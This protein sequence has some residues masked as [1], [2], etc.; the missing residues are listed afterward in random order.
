MLVHFPPAVNVRFIY[1]E[2]VI[3]KRVSG[4]DRW[5]VS[6]PVTR[7]KRGGGEDTPRRRKNAMMKIWRLERRTTL[8]A[9]LLGIKFLLT[10]SQVRINPWISQFV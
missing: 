3:V 5:Y 10:Q 8:L 6:S 7:L 1:T 9:S 2:A 4:S